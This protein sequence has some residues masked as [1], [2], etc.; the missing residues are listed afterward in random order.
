MQFYSH[1]VREMVRYQ[2]SRIYSDNR[3]NPDE[4]LL[5]VDLQE[6]FD[7][8]FDEMNDLAETFVEEA[9]SKGADL[10]EL[11]CVHAPAHPVETSV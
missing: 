5:K 6:I 11:A 1:N 8:S 2:L 9:L 7:L 4:A 3:I 10:K